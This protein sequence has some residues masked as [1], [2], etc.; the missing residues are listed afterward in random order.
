MYIYIY[1][2]VFSITIIIIIIIYPSIHI[3]LHYII[4][5][6]YSPCSVLQNPRVN[7]DVENG[8]FMDSLCMAIYP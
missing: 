2:S 6:A 8:P 3:Y 4:L 7:I 5:V 1:P